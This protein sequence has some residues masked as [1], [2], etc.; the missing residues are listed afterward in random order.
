MQLLAHLGHIAYVAALATFLLPAVVSLPPVAGA[1][2]GTGVAIIT[3][4][5]AIALPW[6]DCLRTLLWIAASSALAVMLT[7]AL[8]DCS[9]CGTAVSL[10]DAAL[11]IVCALM[12]IA[13]LEPP[14]RRSQ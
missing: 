1:T 5:I 3:G 10:A 14:S 9:R 11:L 7:Y 4:L 2:M 6:D 12:S 8:T 13:P